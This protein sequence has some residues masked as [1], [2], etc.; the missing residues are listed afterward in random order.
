MHADEYLTA[1]EAFA[2]AGVDAAAWPAA[3]ASLASATRSSGGELIG[4]GPKG[5]AFYVAEDLSREGYAE[6][7]AVGG[8]SPHVNHRIAAAQRAPPMQVVGDREYDEVAPLLRRDAAY[9]D[10]VRKYDIAQHGCQ[11][12]L[13][14]EPD[15]L[16][17]LS[18]HRRH[19]EGRIDADGTAAFARLAPH[20]LAAVRTRLA[21]GDRSLRDM[22][23][24][25][26]HAGV[27][28]FLCDRDGMVCAMT[29][30]AEQ[31]AQDARLVTLRRRRLGAERMADTVAI[32]RAMAGALAGGP[33]VETVV[34]GPEGRRAVVH[35]RALAEADWGLPF[36][37]RLMVIVRQ[38]PRKPSAEALRLAFGLTP[39]EAQIA[40]A[41]AAGQP[42]EAV[43]VLRGV[44]LGTLRQ[45][46]KAIFAKVGVSREAE[47][48]VA[49]HGL[50]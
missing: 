20:A 49:V 8:Y 38:G 26:E 10:V 9:M 13:V 44:S 3:L 11:T 30:R 17:G 31:L 40:L 22:T 15:L 5:L 12:T 46:V 18:A 43:A 36:R 4:I 28:A 48:I 19:S 41:L 24:A 16:V 34:I 39:A 2:E 42:R 1:V 32:K 50:G 47:L 23:M 25:L 29:G 35:I 45:Q 7:E 37:A 14:I 21:L 6:F 33:G 27:A